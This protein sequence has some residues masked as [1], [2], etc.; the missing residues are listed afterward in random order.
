MPDRT[1]QASTA[2]AAPAPHTEIEL[3]LAGD[4]KAL[5]A[6]FASPT[7]RN[8]SSGRAQSR[9]LDAV[10]YDTDD[11]R[12]RRE[13]LAF[14]V[15]RNGRRFEQTL[16]A[17]GAGG[18]AFERGEWE[19]R[20]SSAEPDLAAMPGEAGAVLAGLL[21]SAP[22]RALFSTRVRRQIRRLNA[23]NGTGQPCVV[24]A[25]LDLGTIE[26]EGRSI[27][28]A[29]LEL[30][31]IEGT[32]ATLYR[33]ALELDR[34]TPLHVETSSKAARGY[35]LAASAPPTHHK[36]APLVLD[37]DATV[38][39]A[40]EAILRAC[41]RHWTANEAAALDGRDP[42]G[43]HQLR[44]AIRRL[45]SVFS[46]FGKVIPSRE[47]AW[48]K[49]EAR[50]IVTG[51]GPARDWDV[52]LAELVGP[53]RAARPDDPDLAA[54]CAAAE[55]ARAEG[56][57]TARAAIQDPAY[58]SFVLRFGEW[59]ERRGWR[60]ERPDADGPGSRF[61]QPARELADQLLTRRQRKAH[62]RGREFAALSAADRHK[63]RIALKKL[64]YTAEF[65]TSLYPRKRTDT[66][67]K[68][69]KRLQD[70]LGHLNDLAT[71]ERLLDG[72][73]ERSEAK[74]RRDSLQRAAGLV[75]GWH[76]HGARAVEQKTLKKW[77]AFVDQKPFWT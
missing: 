26:A 2:S 66:Y 6:L 30:E 15:R 10:Y 7:L 47:L 42:E 55:V 54:L 25:A 31:L 8:L 49:P 50:R 17:D 18:A 5:K 19:A 32:P 45:R 69:L 60:G 33:L 46:V 62:K 76:V 77:A 16:K 12:L 28:L 13:G 40:L 43:I 3:K 24:E 61:E 67:V 75:L 52:F 21:G 4:P 22:L 9:Q 34:L 70:D 23:T 11:L 71:A 35:A 1:E 65:F 64:R 36:A 58:T 56:Y 39:A 48:L 74:A 37:R 72:L 27:P 14:R 57:A 41:L 38:D 51:L 53:V 63:L 29:E 68:A 20:L 44:V 59:I 73:L